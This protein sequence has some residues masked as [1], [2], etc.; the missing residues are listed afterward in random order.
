MDRRQL[1][2]KERIKEAF[3]ELISE[4][5]LNKITVSGLAK[6]ADI[7]R[8]TFYLHYKDVEDLLESL[9]KELIDDLKSYADQLDPTEIMK[10]H[11]AFDPL[12]TQII[13]SFADHAA[14]IIALTGPQGDP[15]FLITWEQ[16]VANVVLRKFSE[17]PKENHYTPI[18]PNYLA[19]IISSVYT[20][21]VLEWID[22]GMKETSEEIAQLISQF[23]IQPILKDL[24]KVR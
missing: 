19:T 2:T 17:V 1:R 12:L 18:A 24:E 15:S 16:I 3:V 13:S 20:G 23:A 4:V 9:Q 5:G 22:Q 10:D 14:L 7:N 11:T 6:K 8:G 21:V